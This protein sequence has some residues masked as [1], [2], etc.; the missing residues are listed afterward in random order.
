MP[1]RKQL[2]VSK[3]I[4]ADGHGATTTHLI[5]VEEQGAANILHRSVFQ[6]NLERVPLIDIAGVTALGSLRIYNFPMGVIK[7]I[8]STADLRVTKTSAGVND[9]WDGDFSVGS[10]N[11]SNANRGLSGR[12]A[13][14]I[15]SQSTPRAAGG[16]TT[17]RGYGAANTN[18]DGRTNPAAAYI[19]FLIDDADHNVAGTACDLLLSGNIVITWLNLSE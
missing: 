4:S 12:R 6:I 1:S 15:A 13:D 2:V 8:G 9:N 7:I 10:T 17:A 11:V 18:L 16:E 5:R 19:N 14:Y 3:L